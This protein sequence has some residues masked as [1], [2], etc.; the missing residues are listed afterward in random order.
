MNRLLRNIFL[1]A[2][3][4]LLGMMVVYAG[5]QPH[6]WPGDTAPPEK[7]KPADQDNKPE[8]NNDSEQPSRTN[9]PD[10]NTE[11]VEKGIPTVIKRFFP[12]LEKSLATVIEDDENS[13]SFDWKD[14]TVSDAI[15]RLQAKTDINIA[16]TL[17]DMIDK[18]LSLRGK[19]VTAGE[20]LEWICRSLKVK[21]AK[22]DEKSIWIDPQYAWL[23]LQKSE[24][25]S[26]SIRGLYSDL[27]AKD[28]KKILEDSVAPAIWFHKGTIVPI[29][30]NNTVIAELPAQAH[31]R[32]VSLL[33][34]L[35]V[36][37]IEGEEPKFT[38]LP[39]PKEPEFV[40]KTLDEEFICR[41]N[42][43][44]N[45]RDLIFELGELTNTNINFD[46]LIFFSRPIPKITLDLG[47]CTL[48]QALD[49]IIK[50]SPLKSYIVHS[51]KDIWLYDREINIPRGWN[52]ESLWTRSEIKTY[53]VRPL[54]LK[55]G[56]DVLIQAIRK[57]VYTDLWD[58]LSA[59]LAYHENSGKLIVIQVPEIQA[60][61]ER[62]LKLLDDGEYKKLLP[63]EKK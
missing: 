58:D 2:I 3:M 12:K 15:K 26:H 33:R 39:I 46:Q 37:I 50:V 40:K 59:M 7:V 62:Y 57:S 38:A 30:E 43:P 45:L 9:K 29:L 16:V 31:S 11:P 51:E 14:V 1:F 19:N 21:Y 24:V 60:A 61:V 54:A 44:T 42:H 6:R 27:K 10:E 35:R 8:N 56:I 41:F 52:Q 63:A 47:R 5:R 22:T 20:V 36:R 48:R 34:L 49:E 4:S 55:V 53:Y 32:L 13:K 18:R 25:M 23:G 28:I 17:D